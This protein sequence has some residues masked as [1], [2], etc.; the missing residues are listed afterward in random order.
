MTQD[1]RTSRY[2]SAKLGGEKD[3]ASMWGPSQ[4]D[5]PLP[6]RKQPR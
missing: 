1:T 2:G 5:L 3:P 4:A 6:A